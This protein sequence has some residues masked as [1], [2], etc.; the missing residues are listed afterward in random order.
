MEVNTQSD[1]NQNTGGVMTTQNPQIIGETQPAN[2]ASDFQSPVSPDQLDSKQTLSVT[3]EGDPVTGIA[4]AAG[5]VSPVPYAAIFLIVVTVAAIILWLMSRRRKLG[6]NQ[7][8]QTQVGNSL[9]GRPVRPEVMTNVHFKPAR[10]TTNTM[11]T[12]S[13]SGIPKS[14]SSS[15]KAAMPIASKKKSKPPG[16]PGKKKSQRNKKKKG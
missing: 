5:P 9:A 8:G 12:V 16:R 11:P 10:Q 6:Q 1:P 3:R 13:S 2:K 15:T 14:S 4:A 7:A